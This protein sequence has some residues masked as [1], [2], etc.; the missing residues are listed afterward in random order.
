MSRDNRVEMERLVNLTF[1][2]LHASRTGRTSLSA[3]WLISHVRGYEHE[4]GRAESARR[5]LRRDVKNLQLAG[6]PIRAFSEDGAAHYALNDE[7]YALPALSLSPEEATVLGL[8][9]DI[10]TSGALSAF[11]RS[12]WMKLAA[13]GA[14]R[15]LGTTPAVA[16]SADIDRMSPGVLTALLGAHE[17]KQRIEFDYQAMSTAPVVRRRMDL[18]GL[19]AHRSRLYMVGFDLDRGEERAFRI[20]RVSHVQATGPAG[21]E[22]G[23]RNLQDIVQDCLHR[24]G[25]RVDVLF[26]VEGEPVYDVVRQAT[27]QP[28]GT[29]LLRQVDPEWAARTAAGVAPDMVLVSPPEVIEDTIALLRHAVGEGKEQ[30]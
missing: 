9:G 8:A 27:K 20:H 22:P 15:D 21:H 23:E 24:G 28:D 10:G 29:Y 4:E 1:A 5:K 2:F 16:L 30:Q 14:R 7:D 19:V 18:W 17:R 6:V 26:R 11:A 25:E 13:G 12:G 3:D